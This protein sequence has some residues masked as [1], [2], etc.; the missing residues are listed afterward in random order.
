MAGSLDNPKQEAFCLHVAAG[1]S[2]RDAAIAAG[3]GKARASATGSRLA[4]NGKVGQRIAILQA[5][6]SDGTVKETVELKVKAATLD[7]ALK[8]SRIFRYNQIDALLEQV[9]LARAADPLIQRQP[10]G[11]S[12][13]VATTIKSIGS[14]AKQRVVVHSELDTGFVRV[15]LENARQAAVDNGQWKSAEIAGEDTVLLELKK[16]I[17]DSPKE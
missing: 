13:L 6:V 4:K 11:P 5:K 2:K 9:R 17:D 12:G 14:G 7:I 10:G 1:K 16:A 3:Y 15:M 8:E